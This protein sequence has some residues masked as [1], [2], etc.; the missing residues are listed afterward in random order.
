[1]MRPGAAKPHEATM[2][3]D[4]AAPR[5]PDGAPQRPKRVERQEVQPAERSDARRDGSVE[6]EEH[7]EA[8]R[9]HGDDPDAAEGAV[10][11]RPLSAQELDRRNCDA[12]R[13]SGD[14]QA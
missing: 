11:P 12:Y 14:M 8:N 9:D 13:N 1:M 2:S 7:A 10:R 3:R 6:D 5:R 4:F